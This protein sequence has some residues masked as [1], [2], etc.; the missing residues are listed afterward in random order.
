MSQ[1]FFFEKNNFCLLLK[2]L[3]L[4]S[5]S[6]FLFLS[7]LDSSSLN[8]NFCFV[9][10]YFKLY[11]RNSQALR[12]SRGARYVS[13]DKA[14]LRKTI[15]KGMPSEETI[16]KIQ[17]S[18]VWQMEHELYDFALSQFQRLRRRAFGTLQTNGSF[19]VSER[20]QTF[21]YEKIRPK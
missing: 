14:H 2:L 16:A 11:T 19:P 17:Q 10:L 6:F 7:F 8:L 5:Y 21:M 3:K 1:F 15:Q 9:H 4:Q 18:T 20:P 13:G 12:S